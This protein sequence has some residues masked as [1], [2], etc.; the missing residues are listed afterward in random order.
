MNCGI[1]RLLRN[2]VQLP[3]VGR[4]QGNRVGN[5]YEDD[6]KSP[7]SRRKT[8]AA[9]KMQENRSGP[10]SLPRTSRATV[11]RRKLLRRIW[12]GGK[13]KSMKVGKEITRGFRGWERH[14]TVRE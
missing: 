6:L 4:E 1:I 10:C 9:N 7:Q 12:A 5:T 11:Q 8:A 13:E 3:T 2:S 14:R